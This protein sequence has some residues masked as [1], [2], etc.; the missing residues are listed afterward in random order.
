MDSYIKGN[1]EHQDIW[2]PK[3]NETLKAVPQATNVVDEYAV[4]IVLGD[5]IVGHLK[6][7]KTGR[8]AGT[9]SYF[10]W[11]DKKGPCAAIVKGKAVNFG[12]GE[13]MQVPCTLHFKGTKK[14][15]NAL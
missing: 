13:G 8:F 6:E 4:C 10:L 11:G 1:L 2:T 3:L 5:E 7:G 9:I 15:I 12:D 14:F